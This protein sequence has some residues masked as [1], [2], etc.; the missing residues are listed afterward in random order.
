MEAT[1]F[2][3]REDFR[4]WLSANY[5]NQNELWVGFYKVKSGK[6]SITWSESV[7]EA[8]CFGWIDGLRKTID[9]E[10]YKIRFTPRRADSI[11]SAVNLKKMK[12]LMEKG[13]V[14]EVGISIYNK[15]TIDKSSV[16]AFE[17]NP[18]QFDQ[19]YEDQ[20]RKNVKAWSFFETL[21]PS[22]KK[23]S[24]HWVM[25]AKQ[26]TT[27]QRR[28]SQLISFSEAGINQWKDNKYNKKKKS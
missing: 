10:A 16:Y 7:D 19:V 15:R 20:F 14:L 6:E 25:S 23:N 1:F 12:V 21:A 2:K 22:Y 9:A 17:Q 18:L 24:I 11:W 13:L 4:K 8:L 5:K 28:L 3:T 26:E 27:R